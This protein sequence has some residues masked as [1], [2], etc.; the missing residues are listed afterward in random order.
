MLSAVV[1]SACESTSNDTIRE[2]KLELTS[3]SM[4]TVG[5]EGGAIVVTYSLENPVDGEQVKATV[6]NSQMITEVDTS[7]EG[8]V[9]AAVSP[10]TTGAV[11]EGAIV[12][13]YGDSSFTVLVNQDVNSGD[14][15]EKER[16]EVAATQLIGQYYGD[17]LAEGLGHYWLILSDDGIVDGNSVPG[18]EFFR[19]DLL[20]PLATEDPISVPSGR[21]VYD[22]F[23][24]MLEYTIL[25][26]GNSDYTYVDDALEGWA[27]P[28]DNAEL[29]VDGKRFELT[30]TVGDKI[31]HVTFEG[32][33]TIARTEVPDTI[34]NLRGDVAIDVT[35][36]EAYLYNHGDYWKCGYNDWVIEFV[37][38]DGLKYGTY[39]VV[40]LMTELNGN[41][42]GSYH[43]SGFTKED[44]TKPD[45]RPGVFIP[46]FRV[47]D[48]GA[49]MLGSIY[50]SYKDGKGI[51][52][53]PLHEGSVTVAANSDGTYTI[54]VDC[55]DDT[56]EAHKLT[57]NWT[58]VLTQVR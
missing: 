35:N 31:Y 21:Y 22:H 45:F 58:G 52:Q 24:T 12:V 39:F 54:V 13:S 4:V 18:S 1:M 16:V 56:P 44:A 26:I 15:T 2:P 34:S 10:N 47:S 7:E 9:L 50:Q 29:V 23:N 5:G 49:Y 32:D 42:V 30:A 20:G 27:T 46:G 41:I 38:V 55:V 40:E 36:C 6:V 48:D 8:R 53:A 57:L 11:R 17:H 25:N 43:S 37:C 14:N 33:Y 28:F 3:K 19:V 51:D